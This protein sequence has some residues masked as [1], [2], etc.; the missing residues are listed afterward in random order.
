MGKP[1]DLEGHKYNLLFVEKYHGRNKHNQKLWECVCECGGRII[2]STASI[3]TGH[4]KSCGCLARKDLIG[5]RFGS[6]VV[7]DDL[8]E[9]SRKALCKCDCG[10]SK[11]M[12]KSHITSGKTD[13]C[14]CLTFSKRSKVSRT[15]GLS[16]SKFYGVWRAM[17]DRCYL[18]TSERYPNYGARGIYVCDK[19]KKFEGFYEDNFEHYKEGLSIDRINPNLHYTHDNVRW[20]PLREQSLN[21]TM[22]KN[23]K[24]GVTGVYR[25]T[26]SGTDYY[27]AF[28]KDFF[29]ED[30]RKSKA[31]SIKKFGEDVAFSMA[32]ACREKAIADMVDKGAPY[33]EFHGKSKESY[34]LLENI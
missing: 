30:A 17:L 4:T 9:D 2:L 1:I 23:N 12:F 11:I 26:I 24:T 6:L 34:V 25:T 15:H 10:N 19:W 31:F 8:L 29:S 3:R 32:V 13:S 18:E 14:G 22:N 20:I 28:W 21:Y 5:K 16:K 7:I 33:S 27:I